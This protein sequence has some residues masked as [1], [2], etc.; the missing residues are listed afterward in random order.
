M[1]FFFY[2][3]KSHNTN[4]NKHQLFVYNPVN[5][6][7]YLSLFLGIKEERKERKKEQREKRVL[8]EE[9]ALHFPFFIHVSLTLTGSLWCI[10]NLSAAYINKKEDIE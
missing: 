10:K 7:K 2:R 8:D 1:I 4:A 6:F 3:G 5:F 9:K